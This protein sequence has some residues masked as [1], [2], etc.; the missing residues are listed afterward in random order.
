MLRIPFNLARGQGLILSNP[1]DAVEL[2]LADRQSR[3][4]FS[5]TQIADL[6]QVADQEWKA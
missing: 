3:T 1:A 6:I 2:M 4:M 5:R